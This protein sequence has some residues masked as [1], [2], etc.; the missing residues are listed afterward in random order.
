MKKVRIGTRGS[1]LALY[2]AGVVAGYLKDKFKDLEVEIVRI[3]TTGDRILDSPLSKIGDKGLFTKE[4]E[5]AL[6]DNKIDC[7]VHSLK[8]VPT[9]LPPGLALVAYGEREDVRDVFISPDKRRFLEVEKGASIA[10]S[11]L[12]RRSQLLHLRSD[13]TL[14]D[15]RG[16]LQT[17]LKKLQENGYAGIVLAYAGV[18]RLGMLDRISEV[19]STD[20]ILPAVGQ[21]IIAVEAR[22]EDDEIRGLLANYNSRES[23]IA[24]LAERAFLRHL[25]GGC[26][27]PIGVYTSI[28]NLTITGLVASLD[29]EVVVK[30]S[31]QL[32]RDKPEVSG[33]VLAE[34][35]L[36]NGADKILE[37]IRASI[38]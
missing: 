8:D 27:V 2:Q 35:L 19:F 10:T 25:E 17:R 30:K 11:S 31:I 4:I 16:N 1:K 7:A 26:Q 3:K 29:G 13:L 22:Y 6:L 15:V 9:E 38:D 24:A 20:L 18:K 33:K 5:K 21:G 12:R 36:Q 32:V 14:V 28:E 34:T 37:Q 23:E